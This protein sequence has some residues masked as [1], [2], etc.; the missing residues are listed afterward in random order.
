MVFNPLRAQAA[1][2]I[3]VGAW[4]GLVGLMVVAA[5]M[6][7]VGVT[8]TGTGA[9]A[10]AAAEAPTPAQA[11]SLAGFAVMA[12]LFGASREAITRSPTTC[13]GEWHRRLTSRQRGS[14]GF[15]ATYRWML[16]HPPISS[17]RTSSPVPD[18]SAGRS[19][20]RS[21]RGF[22]NRSTRA[23]PSRLPSRG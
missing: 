5:G 4:S 1:L 14:S 11:A 22:Q 16:P 19:R 7:G 18:S 6:D 8:S 13:R 20:T 12:A 3:V 15:P 2:K 23:V 17:S 10:A 21:P 9:Q